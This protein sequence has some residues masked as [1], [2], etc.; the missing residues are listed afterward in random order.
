MQIEVVVFATLRQYMPDLALGDSR[1]MAV[2]PGTTIAQ[3]CDMLGLPRDEV[4]VIMCNHR[5]AEMDQIVQDGD[6]IAFVPAA[7]GG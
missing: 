6:R 1:K 4:K 3:V 2:S 5:Q 7:G